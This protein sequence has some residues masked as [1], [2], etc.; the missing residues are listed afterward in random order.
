MTA[1]AVDSVRGCVRSVWP[2]GENYVDSLSDDV[3]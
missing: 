3:D 1:T 2:P